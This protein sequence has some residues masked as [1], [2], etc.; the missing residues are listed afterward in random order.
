MEG[1]RG[2]CLICTALKRGIS[3]NDELE[4]LGDRAGLYG[5]VAEY[6]MRP[7]TGDSID[8]GFRFRYTISRDHVRSSH[9]MLVR[10]WNGTSF[11]PCNKF[12]STVC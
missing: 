6:S 2:R 12:S 9:P 5:F 3:Q 8:L 1:A 11:S 7:G 4:K 10:P